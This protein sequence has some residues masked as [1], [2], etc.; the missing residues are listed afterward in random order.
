MKCEVCDLEHDGS[1]GSG[2]FC[3]VK[4]A[5]G[6]STLNNRDEINHKRSATNKERGVGFTT[7]GRGSPWADPTIRAKATAKKTQNF[8]ESL[9]TR[10]FETWSKKYR[11]KHIHQKQAGK[12]LCGLGETWEG[13][14]LRLQLDHANGDNT[15]N[16]EENL[17][18]LCPNCHSQTETY[19]GR[20]KRL[21]RLQR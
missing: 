10:P 8:L 1:Y 3:C 11:Y 12:C 5:R 6:F 18:L 20:N 4:C 13:K 19:Y 7:H 21:K 16:R 14:P 2:R 9:T 15:D 17:R